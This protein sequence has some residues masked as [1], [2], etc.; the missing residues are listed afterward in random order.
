MEYVSVAPGKL[1][2]YKESLDSFER[3]KAKISQGET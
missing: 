1:A 2:E 3:G